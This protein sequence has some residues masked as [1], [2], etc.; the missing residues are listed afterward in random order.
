MNDIDGVA[1]QAKWLDKLPPLRLTSC[2][3]ILTVAM[4]LFYVPVAAIAYGLHGQVGVL[5]AAVA[6]G[7]C[8]L[9]ASLAL[10]GTAKFGR[11]GLNGPLFTIAF[12]LIFNCAL[13]FAV[14]LVLSR[15]GGALAEAGVFGQIVI[16]FQFSLLVETLLSLCLIKPSR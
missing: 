16:C 12:G 5:T 10:A 13:P 3:L 11:T 15:S 7:V 14:G 2:C 4:L 6:A 1:V 8:W 9:G